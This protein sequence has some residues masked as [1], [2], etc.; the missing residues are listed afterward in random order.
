MMANFSIG[1]AKG[2]SN[3]LVEGDSVVVLYW[4]KKEKNSRRFGYANFLTSL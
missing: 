4:V 2:L 3:L 1:K